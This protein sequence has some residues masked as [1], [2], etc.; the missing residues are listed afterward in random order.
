MLGIV[1]PNYSKSEHAKRMELNSDKNYLTTLEVAALVDNHLLQV[2]EASVGEFLR[3]KLALPE[4]EVPEAFLPEV[5]SLVKFAR[6][7]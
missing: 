2:T 4:A 1:I 6:G 5:V 3:G 7:E